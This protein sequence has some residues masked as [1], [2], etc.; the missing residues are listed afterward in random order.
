MAYITLTDLKTYGQI[1]A[2]ATADDVTLQS[3]IDRAQA[4]MTLITG[5]AFDE[6]TETLVM[7]VNPFVDAYGWL[8]L[9]AIERGPVTAVTEVKLRDVVSG[10]S[11]WQTL[12]W[13]A[14]DIILPSSAS[15]IAPDAWT[16]RVKSSAP[17]LNSR[18]TGQI[19]VKW[20]YTGGYSSIPAGLKSIALRLSWWIYKLREA[21]LGRV[22]TAELGLM[23]V[24]IAMPPDIRADLRQ[25]AR[26]GN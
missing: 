10:K 16:V 21:P 6:A 8:N 2:T 4:E 7:T 17:V 26:I 22:V 23:E 12:S 25:W 24:P 3:S 14:D 20:T 19:F 18:T 5:S 9:R 13:N 15:P 1:P 11:G